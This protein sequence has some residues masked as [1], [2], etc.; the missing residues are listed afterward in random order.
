MTD[1]EKTH[2]HAILRWWEAQGGPRHGVIAA[3]AHLARVAE[4]LNGGAA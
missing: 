4:K 2:A 3:E 1:Q